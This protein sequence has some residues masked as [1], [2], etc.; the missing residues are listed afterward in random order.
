[1]VKGENGISVTERFYNSSDYYYSSDYYFWQVNFASRVC[2]GD[3]QLFVRA[4]VTCPLE[5]G[6]PEGKTPQLCL[7]QEVNTF[8]PLFVILC[9]FRFH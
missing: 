5:L 9:R 8:L 1:M 6:V 3:L 2:G 4:L 7:F